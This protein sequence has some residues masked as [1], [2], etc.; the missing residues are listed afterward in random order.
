MDLV[1]AEVNE[2]YIISVG[3]YLCM[4]LNKELPLTGNMYHIKNWIN[5]YPCINFSEMLKW[6]FQ[7][8]C[9]LITIPGFSFFEY[10]IFCVCIKHWIAFKRK[11]GQS[12]HSKIYG[13]RNN[14]GTQ[15]TSSFQISIQIWFIYVGPLIF[16]QIVGF[17]WLWVDLNNAIWYEIQLIYS[18]IQMSLFLVSPPSPWIQILGIN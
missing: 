5:N 3:S 7:Y 2:L 17:P 6:H 4:Q 10:F 14:V 12:A 11:W 13:S 1:A 16:Y 18:C 8:W 15:F 9:L